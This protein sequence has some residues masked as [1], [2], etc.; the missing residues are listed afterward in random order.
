M[1]N[2][3][4]RGNTQIKQGTID[5]LRLFS[6]F[7]SGQD[8]DLTNGVKDATIKGIRNAIAADEPVTKG[9]FDTAIAGLT[10]G[11]KFKNTFNASALGAQL[12]DAK[13]G[14]FF[15]VSVAGILFGID[16]QVGDDLYITADIVGTPVD[17][18]NIRKIDNTESTDILRDTDIIAALT[19]TDDTKVLAASQG[20]ILQDQI[21]VINNQLTTKVNGEKPIVTAGQAVLGALANA[22]LMGTLKVFLNGL[23]MNEGAANDYTANYSTGVVTMTSPLTSGDI[24]L[25]DYEF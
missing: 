24:V 23:R 3:Q 20:K 19:S 9:Q 7:L 25:A 11:L 1:A 6:N 17:A 15:R 2:T 8:W 21:D 22:P 5:R 12:D 14:D 16:F 10:G 13:A 4:I 18:S